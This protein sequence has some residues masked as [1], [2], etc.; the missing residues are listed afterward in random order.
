MKKWTNLRD[1]FMKTMRATGERKRRYVYHDQLQF[2]AK[3]V[4]PPKTIKNF[5]EEDHDT[6][7]LIRFES[8]MSEGEYVQETPVSQTRIP[9][10]RIKAKKRKLEETAATEVY[11]TAGDQLKTDNARMMF[12]KSVYPSVEPFTNSQFLEFQIGLLQLIKN[13]SSQS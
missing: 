1:A 10:S 9:S 7:G 6:S 8:S 12:L 2:L 4:Q 5:G 13:I 11:Q 3:V